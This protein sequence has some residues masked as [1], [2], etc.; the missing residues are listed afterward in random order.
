V[1]FFFELI[2]NQSIMFVLLGIAN[3]FQAPQRNAL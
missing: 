1:N 3:Y 2:L